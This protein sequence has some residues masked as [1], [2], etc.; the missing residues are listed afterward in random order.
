MRCILSHDGSTMIVAA[1]TP[2]DVI[3]IINNLGRCTPWPDNAARMGGFDGK[4]RYNDCIEAQ[5]PVGGVAT[6]TD[7]ELLAEADDRNLLPSED[8]WR[9]RAADA[10]AARYEGR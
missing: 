5:M 7:K 10:K 3:T 4:L 6:A 1:E 9:E 2:M 8:D